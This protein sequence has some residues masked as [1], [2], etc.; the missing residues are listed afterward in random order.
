MLKRTI[1]LLIDDNPKLS[2][3]ADLF[4]AMKGYMNFEFLSKDDIGIFS[5]KDFKPLQNLHY[6]NP[7][8]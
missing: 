8:F 2:H 7:K 4:L 3:L 1:I 6:D 5:K